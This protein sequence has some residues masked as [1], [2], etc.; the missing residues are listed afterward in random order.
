M[1]PGIDRLREA[2]SE[3]SLRVANMARRVA[4]R[5][6]SGGLWALRGHQTPAG[7]EDPERVELFGGIG[8]YYRPAAADRAEAIILNVG[9]DHDH[10]VIVATRDEDARQA[11]ED[12]AGALEPGEMAIANAAG[13]AYVRITADGDI[14]IEAKAGHEVLVRQK[15]GTA[16]SLATKADVEGVKTAF[17][18]HTHVVTGTDSTGGAIAGTAA[19]V[20]PA[21]QAP[22]PDGTSVLKGE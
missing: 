9:A 1:R 14:V 4:V 16:E 22:A 5:A 6:T 2:I 19:A 18:A 20:T 11:F 13:N 7:N 17:D 8:V 21:Q 15:D 12:N 3:W 10:P